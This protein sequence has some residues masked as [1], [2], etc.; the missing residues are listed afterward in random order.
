MTDYFTKWIE[1]VPLQKKDPLSVAKALATIFYRWALL[2]SVTLCLCS[3]VGHCEVLQIGSVS[4]R[5]FPT[6]ARALSCRRG[7]AVLC[8][9]SLQSPWSPPVSRGR[10]KEAEMILCI[11]PR[12]GEFVP[13]FPAEALTCTL[14]PPRRRLFC[15][16]VVPLTT[17][18]GGKCV[19]PAETAFRARNFACFSCCLI[20]PEQTGLAVSEQ[21]RAAELS[22]LSARRGHACFSPLGTLCPS[23]TPFPVR[24][25]CSA[26]WSVE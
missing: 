7:H 4:T 1:A 17:V 14:I 25:G 3:E 24:I 20:I 26:L 10:E 22:L 21:I 2:L 13:Q 11:A 6:R 9:C 16:C 15:T 8:I 19:G 12:S 18:P 5:W 23:C